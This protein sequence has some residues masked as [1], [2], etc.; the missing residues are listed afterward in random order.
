[1]KNRLL[2]P[3]AAI[4]AMA[5]AAAVMPAAAADPPTLDELEFD[6]A[7]IEADAEFYT[8]F[9]P[10]G[11]H[12]FKLAHAGGMSPKD[13]CHKDNKNVS[14]LGKGVRHWHKPGTQDA[15]GPCVKA[16]GKSHQFSGNALCKAQRVA[17]AKDREDGWGVAWEVHTKALLRCIQRM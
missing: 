7:L 16:G 17:L 15:G 5:L 8:I 14:G 6:R 13:D 1:M 2:L 10:A 9:T 3:F 11:I 12:G 4:A